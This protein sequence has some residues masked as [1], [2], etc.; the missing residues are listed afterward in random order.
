M[1]S[2]TEISAVIISFNGM[3]FL[4]DCLRTLKEDLAGINHEIIVVDNG[5]VDGSADFVEQEYPDA[6]LIRNGK[7]LGFARA[8]N[9]GFETGTGEYYYILNQDLRFG[10][11]GT[12]SVWLGYRDI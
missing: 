3:R 9:I 11:G 2:P 12:R 10:H 5:S 8:V 6:V 7:N 4:P 1:N